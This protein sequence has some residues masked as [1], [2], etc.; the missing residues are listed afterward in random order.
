MKFFN[1]LLWG[2][3]IGV[4]VGGW[5]GVNIG[6]DAPLLSNPFVERTVSDRIKDEAAE[7]YDE[8]RETLRKSL[9]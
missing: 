2:M 6:R 1:G 3:V 7:V 9:E 8:T 4:C 5:L